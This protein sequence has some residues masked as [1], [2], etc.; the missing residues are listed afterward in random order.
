MPNAITGL[1]GAI[2]ET[3]ATSYQNSPTSSTS[4]YWE[5]S[6]PSQSEDKRIE[7]KPIEVFKELISEKP[8]VDINNV[9]AHIKMVKKRMKFIQEHMGICNPTDERDALGY[10]E[11]R[12]KYLKMRGSFNWET[13]NDTLINKLCKDYKVRMVGI[14]GYYRNMPQ[15][16]LDEMEAFI[17]VYDKVRV[18]LEPTFNLI[19]DDGGKE[20]KKDPILLARSPF[21][22]WWYVLGAWDKEIEIV[23]DLIYKGK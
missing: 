22:K 1:E 21:G 18:D 17:K 12:K 4:A 23:D 3:R 14:S 16:A 15:E 8:E 19:I 9:E 6:K 11:A 20:T 10:L 5:T 2:V 7:K 13:T